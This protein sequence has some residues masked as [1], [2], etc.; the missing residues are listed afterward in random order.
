MVVG[1]FID[2]HMM[3]ACLCISCLH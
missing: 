1:F 3:G 2:V